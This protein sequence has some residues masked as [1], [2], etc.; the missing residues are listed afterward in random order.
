MIETMKGESKPYYLE[1]A[2]RW[3]RAHTSL[4]EYHNA[5]RQTHIMIE[6]K[7]EESK[8]LLPRENH[9]WQD[10]WR[11]LQQISSQHFKGHTDRK[12]SKPHVQHSLTCS[13]SFLP[14]WLLDTASWSPETPSDWPPMDSW[15]SSIIMSVSESWSYPPA[16]PCQ[17]KTLVS[18]NNVLQNSVLICQDAWRLATNGYMVLA[19]DYVSELMLIITIINNK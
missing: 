13:V 9:R 10:P 19:N 1:T 12:D 11:V 3:G 14:V 16:P 7:K 18:H 6:T 2:D 4:L 15:F 17:K 8:P 5:I